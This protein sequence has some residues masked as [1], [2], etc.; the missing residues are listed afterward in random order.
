MDKP[1]E[2][3]TMGIITLRRFA[4]AAAALALSTGCSVLQQ[5]VGTPVAVPQ[6]APR[7][8]VV[9]RATS[10]MLREASGADLVYIVDKGAGQVDVYSYPGASTSEH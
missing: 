1:V 7:V 8:Q 9:H 6:T 5:P 2:R 4:L 10:W 3:L